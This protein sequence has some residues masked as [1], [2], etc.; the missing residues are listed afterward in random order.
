VRHDLFSFSF[1]FPL[2]NN[3][4]QIPVWSYLPV[5]GNADEDD[6]VKKFLNNVSKLPPTL[7]VAF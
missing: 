1:L 2:R 7:S 3:L 5:L 4:P 6:T